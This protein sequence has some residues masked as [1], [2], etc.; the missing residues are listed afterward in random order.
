MLTYREDLGTARISPDEDIVSCST[1]KWRIRYTVGSAGIAR[2]GKV[3]FG[4]PHGFTTPQVDNPHMGGYCTAECSD[5][6]AHL[7][8]RCTRSS[9]NMLSADGRKGQFGSVSTGVMVHV[10]ETSLEEGD[11][12]DFHYG[13]GAP[14]N[15]GA[16]AR[17]I[18]GEARW[19]M[20]VCPTDAWDLDARFFFLADPPVLQ[21]VAAEP[22]SI[23]VVLPSVS[24]A[25]ED[26]DVH[27]TVK[28]EFENTLARPD[29]PCELDVEGG[30]ELGTH[31]DG[32]HDEITRVPA[33]ARKSGVGRVRLENQGDLALESNPTLVQSEED[34][35]GLYWGDL[36]CHS[37]A[38][39]GLNPPEHLCHYARD[40]DRADF[41]GLADHDYLTDEGWEEVLEAAEKYHEDGTFV[42][43]AG[44]EHSQR[45][46]HRNVYFRG[47]ET[48]L[49]RSAWGDMMIRGN[50]MG[51]PGGESWD[52]PHPVVET[53]DG[54][55]D[56][57]DPE[58][59]VVIPHLHSMDWE[60]HNPRFE[61][62][63][64]MYSNWGSRERS[65][66]RYASVAGTDNTDT[67]QHALGLGYRL[68]FVGGGDGHGG[69]PGKDF[70]LRVRG[71]R[72]CGITGIWAPELTR[73]A[74]W[75]AL[76]NRH[77]Y[78]T[79]S[80][81]IIVQ[82]HLGE[83]MMGDEVEVEG[84]DAP[85]ELR[86]Q[87]NGTAPVERITVV[88]NNVDIHVQRPDAADVTFTWPDPEPARDGDY[89]YLRV[90]QAD[91][92]MAWGSPIWVDLATA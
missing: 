55:F 30:L 11:T 3:S 60:N 39:D 72:A 67:V 90:E 48:K 15:P 10:C 50:A 45:G 66:C 7:V 78:A 79:T 9:A 5:P 76:W 2:G 87:V 73:E 54:L 81:R 19:T 85:R 42:T 89:Y 57:L 56:A 33:T 43:F 38:S 41:V 23:H 75:D 53:T 26:I 13:V 91:G 69:R 84:P 36:H 37:R 12:I 17:T 14:D 31:E 6:D 70:W 44:Y 49:V 51:Y 59:A 34:S 82:C 24:R 22:R 47:S 32:L 21:V 65:G 63:V 4:V 8:L 58:K 83:A 46:F 1:G 27:L 64:E 18:E 71:A 86:V 61:P 25:G 29:V 16:V 68:G 28:D 62:V 35:L 80:R 40:V 92:A 20:L 77:C 74:L 88:K 52:S